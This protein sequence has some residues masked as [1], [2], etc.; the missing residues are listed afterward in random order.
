MAKDIAKN[1]SDELV[2][3]HKLLVASKPRGPE[4]EL[5]YSCAVRLIDQLP[6]G[7]SRDELYGIFEKYKPKPFLHLP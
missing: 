4:R 2:R 5:A 7:K 6:E 3:L 1:V